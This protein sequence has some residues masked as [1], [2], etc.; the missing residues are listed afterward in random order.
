M[1]DDLDDKGNSD[2][3]LVKGK[4]QPVPSKNDLEQTKQ[5]DTTKGLAMPLV[6]TEASLKRISRKK[7]A[8]ADIMSIV[9]GRNRRPPPKSRASSN[10]N[11]EETDQQENLTGLRVKKIMRR[12]GED[13]ESSMLVQKLRN[14]I[15]EAVRNKCSKEFGEKLA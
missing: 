8:N 15:R 12:A 11:D 1:A 4:N 13:Q 5:D 6:P 10:S 9:R 3:T 2:T 7:D 14:E